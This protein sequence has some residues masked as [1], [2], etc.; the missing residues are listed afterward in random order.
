MDIDFDPPPGHGLPLPAERVW[1]EFLAT[2]DELPADARAVLLLHE[3][4]GAGLDEIA[5]LIGLPAAACGQRLQRAQACLR[6]HA[7]HLEPKTP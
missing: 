5:C 7:R 3:V 1:S 4:F 2:L 6:A